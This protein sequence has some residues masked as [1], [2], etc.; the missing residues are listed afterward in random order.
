VTTSKIGL[1]ALAALCTASLAHAQQPLTLA[2][3]TARA[4]SR[5]HDIR[6]ARDAVEAAGAREL[7]ANG[8]YDLRLHLEGGDHYHRDPITTLFSG[9]P[10]GALSPWNNDITSAASLTQ[11]FK[12]GATASASASVARDM[13]NN[14]FTLFTP[15]FLTSL[16]A[17]VRQPL[18][19]GRKVD[20]ARTNLIIT[21]LDRSRSGYVLN[22]QLQD[23][24]SA[25]ERAYWSL[26]SAR[27]EVTVR[28]ASVSLAE[29]QRADT[30]AR[31]DARTAAA[32][33]I[34]Q[35]VAEVERR[36]G[37]LL[38]AQEAAVRA[39]R[40]L[41]LLMT[42]D[43]G[44]PIWSQ[45]LVPSDTVDVEARPV[46]LQRA[47][48]DANTHRPE[49]AALGADVSVA[50]AQV[51]LAKDALR[52]QFDVVA[53]YTM[54]GLAG[55]R[56][57]D[58]LVFFPGAPTDLPA[59]LAGDL[60]T[61]WRAMAEQRFPDATVA[62]SVDIPLGRRQAKGDLGV[63]QVQQRD[64]SIR[65]QQMRDRVMVEVLNAATALET[66]VGRIQ[67]ARAGLQ[68][69][70]TQL[71]AEQDRFNAGTSTNFLVLT[72]QNDLAQAQLTEISAA[73]QYRQALTDFGRATGMLLTERGITVK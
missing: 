14:V 61:S 33:D 50:E 30:Q 21:A 38:T 55:A 31:I 35:P 45:T 16:G 7:S 72:R 6:I 62:V 10:P 54:R 27:R 8:S 44:D 59:P 18:M 71:Q 64:A 28:Q 60:F 4:L 51:A 65:L 39:E 66:A 67:A 73:T 19:R 3:A 2:E 20:P 47:L 46:D 49:L 32:L 58:V 48:T 43:P 57:Q 37:D 13:T 41:K 68:A 34:A 12:S 23:T 52:P 42:D 22:Q 29:Q 15:A 53:G 1:I 11:L 56:N 40:T 5:N 63:A 9:A 24:V 70:T 17:Q 36:R 69:A 26:I 25:V